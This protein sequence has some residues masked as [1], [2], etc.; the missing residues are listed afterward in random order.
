M[1]QSVIHQPG[2]IW[3]LLISVASRARTW[4]PNSAISCCH[5]SNPHLFLK[6]NCSFGGI[7]KWSDRP[8]GDALRARLRS[9]Y[10]ISLKGWQ[11]KQ[12]L[13]FPPSPLK[14]AFCKTLMFR[15]MQIPPPSWQLILNFSRR[16]QLP[17]ENSSVSFFLL[18]PPKRCPHS[19]CFLPLHLC[20]EESLQKRALHF[21]FPD[22]C[23]VIMR[24]EDTKGLSAG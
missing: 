9:F 8:G 23:K 7:L 2:R 19:F 15:C 10:Q 21:F 17:A 20:H 5:I 16:L 22:S 24:N 14:A 3:L 18:C 4:T 12:M 6:C 1:R 11:K 13:V